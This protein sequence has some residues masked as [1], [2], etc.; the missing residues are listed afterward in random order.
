MCIYWLF[1]EENSTIICI[2]YIPVTRPHEVW[3]NKYEYWNWIKDIGRIT[4]ESVV[5]FRDTLA[6]TNITK[7]MI[8]YLPIYIFII[9][10]KRMKLKCN[11]IMT[12]QLDVTLGTYHEWQSSYVSDNIG[13]LSNHTFTQIHLFKYPAYMIKIHTLII[14]QY[15]HIC[16]F[17]NWYS[18]SKTSYG[19]Y[20]RSAV[21]LFWRSLRPRPRLSHD[22][23][24]CSAVYFRIIYFTF[25]KYV[26]YKF[27][28]CFNFQ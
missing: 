15:G 22:M 23:W 1:I 25:E 8:N 4:Y 13:L 27:M 6:S 2:K 12:V 16:L 11:I 21:C 26:F 24:R 9:R 28:I 5:V 3:T 17:S 14:W 7:E 20:R 18:T 19:N 10:I